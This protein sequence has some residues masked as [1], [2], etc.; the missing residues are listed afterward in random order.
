MRV[1]RWSHGY[2]L[3]RDGGEPAPWAAVGLTVQEMAE[4]ERCVAAK[5]P[6]TVPS[7]RAE[8]C[9]GWGTGPLPEIGANAEPGRV[10]E[11]VPRLAVCRDGGRAIVWF[12]GRDNPYGN[13][14]EVIAKA[15]LNKNARESIRTRVYGL[16]VKQAGKRFAAF[17]RS[18][19]VV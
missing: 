1:V 11:R 8:E 19:H 16:A 12:H 13:P 15:M 18:V 17:D 2:M 4:L 6:Q 9:V 5:V 3:P 10:W 7:S 14:L